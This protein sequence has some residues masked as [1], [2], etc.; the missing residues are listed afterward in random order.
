MFLL[1]YFLC[2]AVPHF[3]LIRKEEEEEEEEAEELSSRPVIRADATLI[4]LLFDG[5]RARGD[6]LRGS[7]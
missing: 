6:Y 4:I 1:L 2:A 5:T 7:E 3:A